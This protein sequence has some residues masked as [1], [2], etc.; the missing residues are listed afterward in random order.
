MQ[1]N[2]IVTQGAAALAAGSVCGGKAL[3]LARLEAV[4]AE[5]PAWVCLTTG[6][7]ETL[8]AANDL[9]LPETAA[10]LPVFRERL[11]AIEWPASWEHMLLQALRRRGL[12]GVPVAVR[13]SAVVE[14]AADAS[15]AGQFATRLYVEGREALK[16]AI[17]AC[18]ASAF[19]DG[20]AAY[21]RSRGLPE[22][23]YRIALVVQRMVAAEAAGVTFSMSPQPTLGKRTL[24]IDAVLGLGEGLVSGAL[25]ADHFEVDRETLTVAGRVVRK[26]Q[27]CVRAPGGG[28]AFADVAADRADLPSVDERTLAALARQALAIEAAAGRPQDI[29]W[30]VAG[31]RIYVL[32]ARPITTLPV[33]A[34]FDPAVVGD[35]ITIWDNSNIVESYDGVTSPLTFSHAVNAYKHVYEQFCRVMGVPERI[36]AANADLFSNMLGHVRG[37]VYYNLANWYRLVYLFPN[38]DRSAGFME[39]MMGVRQSL[40]ADAEAVLSAFKAAYHPGPLKKLWLAAVTVYRFAFMNRIIGRFEAR[41]NGLCDEAMAVDFAKLPVT[42]QLAYYRGLCDRLLTSWEAPII[43]DCRC[44]LFFGLLKKLTDKWFGDGGAPAYNELL[45]RRGAM[46]SAEPARILMRIAERLRSGELAGRAWAESV[47]PALAAAQLRTRDDLAELRSECDAYLKAFGFRCPNELKLEEIDLYDDASSLFTALKSYLAA[48]PSAPRPAAADA[49]TS[50]EAR[51]VDE[52]VAGLPAHKRW[53]YRWVL[54]HAG[55]AIEDRERLRLLRTR[56]FGIARRIFRAAGTTLERLE[57]LRKASDI[58]YLTIEELAQFADGRGVSLALG[59]IAALR[60]REYDALRA[61]PPPPARFVVRGCVGVSLAKSGML[62][63]DQRAADTADAAGTLRGTPCC[64]GTVTGPAHVARTFAE[65]QGVAGRILVTERTD[66]GWVSVY[67][68]CS[69]LLV[70]RGSLLSHSAVVAREMGLPTIV[71]VPGLMSA[72]KD[73][74]RLEVDGAAGVV[75]LGD[76]G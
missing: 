6:F 43:N 52:R 71:G 16:E 69:A 54:R 48:P 27:A 76:V 61:S 41:V 33:S 12:D 37:R 36:I 72:I 38:A 23:D 26:A 1:S 15:C 62:L 57:V 70:E 8:L 58:F 65:A 21:K 17:L 64:H 7:F 60:S 49:G 24:T 68:S 29:E 13:S 40:G 67:P 42:R 3:G 2:L 28:V 11:A 53:L 47:D 30:A 18:W 45:S 14:D 34:A 39:T 35:D 31:G 75:R 22:S 59:D 9:S 10:D 4:G 51:A 56:T 63:T 66:P 73:G 19:G 20:V 44:M 55:D 25:D 46:L 50:G 5:V 32:Q 74:Q